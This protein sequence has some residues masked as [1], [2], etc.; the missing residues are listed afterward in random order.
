MP[1]LKAVVS[2][3]YIHGSR[4]EEEYAIPFADAIEPGAGGV[5][6]QLKMVMTSLASSSMKEATLWGVFGVET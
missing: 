5:V 4:I 6:T 1:A 2:R 3:Q